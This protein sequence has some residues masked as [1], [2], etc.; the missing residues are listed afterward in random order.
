MSIDVVDLREFYATPLGRVAAASLTAA[1][2]KY[3]GLE[4]AD[5]ATGLVG[6]GYPVAVLDTLMATTGPN[7]A[8]A[9]HSLVFMPA[10]QGAIKWPIDKPSRTA[11]VQEDALP[12]ETSSVQC[13]IAVHL[14]E[15]VSDPA[16]ILE[17]IWRILVPEGRLILVAANRR[18][19]WTRFEHT[20]F[21]HGRP[22][23]K[24]QLS[25]L[26]RKAKLTPVRWG[27]CLNFPPMRYSRL[28]KTY[29]WIERVAHRVWPVFCGAYV[30]T[31]RKR[32]Y[33]GVATKNTRE[34]RVLVPVLGTQ[35]AARN[36]QTRRN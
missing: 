27:D 10:R 23:S 35:G 26:M 12:L 14:L 11:L 7:A 21:G 20:P 1:V 2:R 18:G 19:L 33:Q 5:A 6:I 31:A 4:N 25:N 34:K 36:G 13:V 15:N 29:P 3:G 24:G 16:A 9:Q 30:V 17:E 22:F 8:M 32:L 28:I